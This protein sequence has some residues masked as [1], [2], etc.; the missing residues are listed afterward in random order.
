[1]ASFIDTN[2][3]LYTDDRNNSAKQSLAL[4][5]IEA[6]RL[7]GSGVLSTQVLTEYFNGAT[8][9]LGVDVQTARRKVEIFSRFQ[10]IRIEADL[11]LAA[12]DLH[13]LHQFSIWDAL[14]IKAAQAANCRELLTEDLQ[15]G[16]KIDGLGIRNPFLQEK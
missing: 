4:D 11:I 13:R 8:R 5:L 1:M 2:V 14:I 10:L 3:L 7:A 15:H 9:K 16:Q 6:H 12:I